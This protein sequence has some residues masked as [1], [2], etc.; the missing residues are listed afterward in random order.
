MRT[1]H[2]RLLAALWTIGII[3]AVTVPTGRLPEPQPTAG[4]DK[5]VHVVL[6]MGFG[7]LWLR[8]LCPPGS[9][10][11]STGVPR[12]SIFFFLAGTLFAVGTEVYQHLVLVGRTG[13]PYDAAADL[14][15]L[16]M[17]LGSYH[18]YHGRWTE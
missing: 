13:D 5:L 4:I 16:L 15:G 9:P 2:Y 11:L 3:V 7:I 12:R 6:F 1:V 17:A 18:A 8:G 10:E 14:L